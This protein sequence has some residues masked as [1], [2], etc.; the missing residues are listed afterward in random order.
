M[1]FCR[2]M[3][4]IRIWT[5]SAVFLPYVHSEDKGKIVSPG[6]YYCYFRIRLVSAKSLRPYVCVC[7]LFLPSDRDLI[8]SRRFRTHARPARGIAD[9]EMSRKCRRV[10]KYVTICARQKHNF[11]P[12]GHVW[13]LSY[14][15]GNICVA[16]VLITKYYTS[17][18]FPRSGGRLLP[19]TLGCRLYQKYIIKHTSCV[20]ECEEENKKS[21]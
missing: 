14:V 7:V 20:D 18:K 17:E 13:Q 4:S 11:P 9:G 1:S 8:G 10:R 16:D 5:I 2:L 6:T 3:R 21:A 15:T 19:C 12:R